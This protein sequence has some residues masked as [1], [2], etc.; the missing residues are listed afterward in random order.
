MYINVHI[1]LYIFGTCLHSSG[2]PHWQAINRLSGKLSI[3]YSITNF[4]MTDI[5]CTPGVQILIVY[6]ALVL[7]A[8]VSTI[9][10]LSGHCKNLI[11]NCKI[12]MHH[13]GNTTSD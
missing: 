8:I 7:L 6:T 2:E 13:V 12:S 11:A 4:L 3:F 5:Q 10:P 1:A 9:P